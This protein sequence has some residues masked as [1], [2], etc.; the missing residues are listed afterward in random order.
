MQSVTGGKT[1]KNLETGTRGCGMIARRYNF[2]GGKSIH[3]FSS[4]GVLLQKG[5]E[6]GFPCFREN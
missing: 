5:K 1:R 4:F 3:L 6:E 2:E